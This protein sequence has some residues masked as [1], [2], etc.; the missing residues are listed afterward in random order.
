M[1]PEF[2]SQR[3]VLKKHKGVI[4]TIFIYFGNTGSSNILRRVLNIFINN[5]LIDFDLNIIFSGDPSER[6]RIVRLV[7]KYSFMKL[8]DPQPN[9]AKLISSSDL[10]IGAGGSTTWERIYL[11]L[12]SIVITV[13]DNQIECSEYLNSL[14]LIWLIGHQDEVSD[15][16]IVKSIK[17]V[18]FERNLEKNSYECLSMPIGTKSELVIDQILQST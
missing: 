5:S 17:E 16:Q 6:D 9:L 4:E 12:P 14:G 1:D 13:A 15:K 18:I 10:S 2:V 11:G 7:G 8:L 3:K